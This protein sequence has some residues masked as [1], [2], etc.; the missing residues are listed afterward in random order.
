MLSFVRRSG[1]PFRLVAN[2]DRLQGRDLDVRAVEGSIPMGRGEASR[3][4]AA[5][6]WDASRTL[7]ESEM[8]GDEIDREDRRRE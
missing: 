8:E 6:W 1:V 2:A 7:E 3:D 4:P 5:P